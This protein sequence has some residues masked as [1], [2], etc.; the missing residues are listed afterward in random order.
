[1]SRISTQ[2][3]KTKETEITLSLNLDSGKP[4]KIDTPIPFFTHMLELF[5]KHGGFDIQGDV[6]GD[7]NVDFHHTVEDTGIVLGN[8]FKEA[9]GNKQGIQRY[10]CFLLPMDETLVE[11]ALDIS[12]RPYFKCNFKKAK[13][14][15][16][17]FDLDYCKHFFRSFAFQSQITLHIE[18]RHG[19]D[20]H[21][22]AEAI[23]KGVAKALSQAVKIVGKD[24]PSTKGVL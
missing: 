21:H 22:I 12:G 7:V 6:K 1:M 24:I 5:S 3:R 8:A 19:E 18:L 11:V 14:R 4:A 20:I 2:N 23:F 9:L 17:D 16:G 13:G 10:G 15:A